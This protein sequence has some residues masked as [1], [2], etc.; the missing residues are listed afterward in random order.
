MENVNKIKPPTYHNNIILIIFWFISLCSAV[1]CNRNKKTILTKMKVTM[2]Y[3]LNIANVGMFC[4]LKMYH[5]IVVIILVTRAQDVAWALF[6]LACAEYEH[7][8]NWYVD[9][10]KHFFSYLVGGTL[11][12][13]WASHFP[14]LV[15]GLECR[16]G[17][18]NIGWSF[19][20]N[21]RS[22]WVLLAL[23]VYVFS[24]LSW[25]ST[26]RDLIMGIN[27]ISVLISH[28]FSVRMKMFRLI[29]F[30][31]HMWAKNLDTPLVLNL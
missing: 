22:F 11:D 21:W 26:I 15:V 18:E 12:Y 9:W 4:W 28:A 10:L 29:F 5:S 30:A 2:G 20:W 19:P 14:L 25:K 24:T 13:R 27:L 6:L 31:I 16:F 1:L 8:G 23:D 3:S 7:F 17:K